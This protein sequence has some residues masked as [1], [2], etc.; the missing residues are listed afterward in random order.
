M[1]D[2]ESYKKIT[3]YLKDNKIEELTEYL[4]KEKHKDYLRVARELIKNY[5]FHTYRRNNFYG[6]LDNKNILISDYISIYQ[7]YSDE[8]LT[9]YYKKKVKDC[10]FL[11]VERGRILLN[12]WFNEPSYLVDKMDKDD[13]K[14]ELIN[15]EQDII[16]TFSFANFENME[17]FLGHDLEYRILDS[18]MPVCLAESEKGKGLILGI[19]KDKKHED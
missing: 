16:H 4:E 14:I 10:H 11:E 19:G 6:Y 3:E 9:S 12:K 7:L 17:K 1:I 2:Y 15:E 8:I 18:K 13:N 5:Y